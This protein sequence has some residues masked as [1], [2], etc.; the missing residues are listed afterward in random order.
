MG[1]LHSARAHARFLFGS[2]VQAA[3]KDLIAN[4][5]EGSSVR[6]RSTGLYDTEDE[7]A[8]NRRDFSRCLKAIAKYADEF[9][10]LCERYMRMDQ[11]AYWFEPFR[12]RHRS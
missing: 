2:D 10:R 7:R 9:P 12:G 8:A 6:E 5:A 4:M 1:P 11:K 3:I